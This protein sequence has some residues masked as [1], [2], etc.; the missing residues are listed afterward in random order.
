MQAWHFPEGKGAESGHAGEA[1]EK[2]EIRMT[3]EILEIQKN[4]KEVINLNRNVMKNAIF[5]KSIIA[6]ISVVMLVSC[7]T[8]PPSPK[9]PYESRRVAINKTLPIEVDGATR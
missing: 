5:I 2:K 9:K 7:T 4:S 3:I 1:L 8:I 6:F